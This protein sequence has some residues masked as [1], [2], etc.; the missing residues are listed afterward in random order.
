MLLQKFF[1]VFHHGLGIEAIEFHAAILE[2]EHPINRAQVGEPKDDLVPICVEPSLDDGGPSLGD[3]RAENPLNVVEEPVLNRDHIAD[4]LDPFRPPLGEDGL[5]VRRDRRERDL[6]DRGHLPIG[7]ALQDLLG[8]RRA[9]GLHAGGL[10]LGEFGRLSFPPVL[11]IGHRVHLVKFTSDYIPQAGGERKRLTRSLTLLLSIYH[12][13]L[14][15]TRENDMNDQLK[16]TLVNLTEK[17]IKLLRPL[18]ESSAG[19][20]HDFGFTEDVRGVFDDPKTHPGVLA[21]LQEKGIIDIGQPVTNDSGTWTQ[22]NFGTSDAPDYEVIEA[23]TE[24]LS[25]LELGIVETQAQRDAMKSQEIPP[26]KFTIRVERIVT[27]FIDVEVKARNLSE[28]ETEAIRQ[29]NGHRRPGGRYAQEPLTWKRGLS[30]IEGLTAIGEVAPAADP[31][32]TRFIVRS[33]NPTLLVGRLSHNRLGWIFLTNVSGHGD[34]RTR[35]AVME[36]AIPRWARKGTKVM[37]STQFSEMRRAIKA[38]K[39]IL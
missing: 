26:Q 7:E 24:Y 6:V 8:D 38:E 15:T 36:Q 32:E 22:F 30:P 18:F 27:E 33:E 31:H 16:T 11:F 5:D 34:G 39:F 37:T 13:L 10:G 1:D 9:S 21:S 28:A 14:I 29:V 17:E 3:E 4:G 25:A 23:V 19:N 20:G 2:G 35:R 12:L